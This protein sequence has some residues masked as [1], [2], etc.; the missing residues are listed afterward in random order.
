MIGFVNVNKPSGLTSSKV[1]SILKKHFNISK[2]G[3][4]GTLDPLAEGVLPIALGKATRM[5]DYLLQKH[6]VYIAEFTFGKTTNTLDSDGQITATNEHIPT[7]SDIIAILPQLTGKISQLP[8]QFSAKK[9]NGRCAYDLARNGEFVD[10]KPKEIEIYNI[11]LLKQVDDCTFRF[12]I[13]CSG[14]TYIR[15]IARDMAT[16]LNSEAYMSKLIRS[17]AGKFNI[18][19]SFTIDEIKDKTLRDIIIN[20]EDVFDFPIINLNGETTKNLLDGKIVKVDN[21]N[22][23]YFIKCDKILIGIGEVNNNIL[24]IKTYLKE[25]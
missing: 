19:K 10:L 24:K 18:N 11:A 13:E 25:D 4:M 12:E 2:I 16:L 1:V 23:Q 8:P 15:S 22:G 14:G 3:H 9:V 20:I 6:K 7:K 5:F 17:S 21:F